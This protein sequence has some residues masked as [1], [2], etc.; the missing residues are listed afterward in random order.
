V[1]VEGFQF[2]GGKP[3]GDGAAPADREGSPLAGEAPSFQNVEDGDIP[4]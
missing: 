3:Q 1:V 4:F 2:L